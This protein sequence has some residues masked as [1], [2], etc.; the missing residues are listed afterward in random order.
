MF[1]CVM[2]C[3]IRQIYS[4]YKKQT[5]IGFIIVLWI[6]LFILIRYSDVVELVVLNVFDFF[7]RDLNTAQ[8]V[9]NLNED[10][11]FV[12]TA[13]WTMTTV[14]SGFVIVYYENL[15]FRNY[16]IVNR[17]IFRFYYGFAFIQALIVFNVLLVCLMTYMYYAGACTDFYILSI[18]SCLLQGIL[19]FCC[20]HPSTR[21]R[22]SAIILEIEKKQF[23]IFHAENEQRWDG[24][25]SR[26]IGFERRTEAKFYIRNVLNGDEYF[27]EKEEILSRILE[28]PFEKEYM[29]KK[30]VSDTIY[31]YEYKN[32]AAIVEHVLKKQEDKQELY[33][34]LYESSSGICSKAYELQREELGYAYAGALFHVLIPQKEFEQKWIFL[35]QFLNYMKDTGKMEEYLI[36]ELLMSIIFMQLTGEL[37]LK[38]KVEFGKIKKCFDAL[39]HDT[40]LC[41]YVESIY[42]SEDKIFE[43]FKSML[44]SW[45]NQ[46]SEEQVKRMET[47]LN[48]ERRL[49]SRGHDVSIDFLKMSL[50]KRKV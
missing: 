15:E 12:G 20:I 14:L 9:E 31:R 35:T 39:K 30:A 24:K 5:L 29:N 34:F 33:A 50:Q 18:Y 40:D 19:I 32:L 43:E 21:K 47:M 6:L 48:V 11:E 8:F 2:I 42:E 28:I 45:I 44:A 7:D 36:L 25:I 37:D 27:S 22:S 49:Y 46:I 38:D 41:E 26:E 16:G 10:K 3:K 17:T 13:V 1:R 23:Q 4:K